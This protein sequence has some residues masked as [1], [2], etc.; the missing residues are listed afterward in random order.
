MKAKYITP[1][2]TV[3]NKKG[4]YDFIQ[5]HLILNRVINGGVNGILLLGSSAEFFAFSLDEKKE[6]ILNSFEYVNGRTD[7]YVGTGSMNIN[8]TL[9]LNKYCDSIGIRKYMIISPYYFDM[10][11]DSLYHYYDV[12]ASNTSSDI[13]LY[14]YPDRTGYD[15]PI[16]VMLKL[17]KK[18]KNIKG[19]KD[20]TGDYSRVL[21]IIN[22]VKSVYPEFEIY[23]G[24]DNFFSATVLAGGNG[25][26]GAL[27]N[28]RP[29]IASAL[30]KAF[31]ENNLQE[32]SLQQKK[33]DNLSAIYSINKPFMT[34]IKY[35]M[36]LEKIIEND[37]SSIPFLP[38]NEAQKVQ[39]KQILNQVNSL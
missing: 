29:D 32:I 12:I 26:I 30:V 28:I 34:S 3:F 7:V 14:S 11:D 27:S 1:L 4:S 18:H 9:N 16:S 24:I 33:L 17:C 10:S 15:I 36:I 22:E 8:D 2:V 20:S 38:V 37:Y 39:I 35:A 25:A 5:N 23:A 6:I 13:Y 19:I 31:E 21:S